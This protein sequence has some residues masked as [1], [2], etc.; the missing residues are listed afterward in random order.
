MQD[1]RT[2]QTLLEIV[3][4]QRRDS[5]SDLTQHQDGK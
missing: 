4:Q 5:W 2:S 3:R 1:P